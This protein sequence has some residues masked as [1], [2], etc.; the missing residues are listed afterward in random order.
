M[1]THAMGPF[2]FLEYHGK[3][4]LTATIA[5]FKG[6]RMRCSVVNLL[7]MRPETNPTW[8]VRISE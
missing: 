1:Q 5:D 3:R 7:P 2:K 4:H 8:A 6:K